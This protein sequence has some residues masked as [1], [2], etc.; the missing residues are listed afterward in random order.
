MTEVVCTKR[1]TAYTHLPEAQVRGEWLRGHDVV[2]IVPVEI[3]GGDGLPVYVDGGCGR[4]FDL[5]LNVSHWD[6]NIDENGKVVERHLAPTCPWCGVSAAHLT[7]PIGLL[8]PEDYFDDTRDIELTILYG[9]DY[10]RLPDELKHFARFEDLV[11]YPGV[12]EAGKRGVRTPGGVW[13]PPIRGGSDVAYTCATEG[14]V[15]L[16]A[17]TAKTVCGVKAHANS[18][19]NWLEATISFDGV[20]A[21]AVPALVELVYCTFGANP[22]GTNSTSTTPRQKYGRSLT[23]GF[24]SGKTWTTEPT[25][26]TVSGNERLITPNGG[27]DRWSE[28]LGLEMDTALAEGFGIRVTAPASVNCRAS[29]LAKR[30]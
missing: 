13:F 12:T 22:P 17:A 1:P 3:V 9:D 25:T 24:T 14:A 7:Q 19:L 27:S 8:T 4:T 10:V 18:G 26:I 28:P 30:I 23:A 11:F 21:S 5:D 29:I 6:V 16:T 15:A 2:D 20:A